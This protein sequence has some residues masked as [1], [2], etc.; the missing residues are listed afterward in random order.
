[1]SNLQPVPAENSP[2][3]LDA[4][5]RGSM[6]CYLI[7]SGGVQINEAFTVLSSSCRGVAGWDS[8]E[9]PHVPGAEIQ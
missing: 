6:R 8:G 1:M 7:F 4:D 3:Q 2:W 9:D 5:V